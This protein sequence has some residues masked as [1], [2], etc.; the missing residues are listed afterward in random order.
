MMI[1]SSTK[2]Q[3]KHN[4]TMYMSK[5]VHCTLYIFQ[6]AHGYLYLRLQSDIQAHRK[7]N[8]A[9]TFTLATRDCHV[10]R[11]AFDYA[12]LH[13]SG[14]DPQVHTCITWYLTCAQGQ[15]WHSFYP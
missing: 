14:I 12:Y 7:A 1:I 8:M 3:H 10:K 15:I 9:P 6:C 2:K 4:Y 13:N 5:L 11:F